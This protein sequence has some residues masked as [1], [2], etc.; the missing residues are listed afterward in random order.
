MP[1][2]NDLYE[3][4]FLSRSHKLEAFIYWQI[5]CKKLYIHILYKTRKAA[6]VFMSELLRI[7]FYGTIYTV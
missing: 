1:M 7:S 3:Q 2:H 6:L 5:N 4:D